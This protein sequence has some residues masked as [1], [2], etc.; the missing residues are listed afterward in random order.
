MVFIC[1]NCKEVGFTLQRHCLYT[2]SRTSLPSKT[3]LV[4]V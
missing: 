1:D 2:A 3:N 4:A